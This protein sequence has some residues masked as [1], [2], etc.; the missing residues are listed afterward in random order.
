MTDRQPGTPDEPVPDAT[1]P[2]E[3]VPDATEPD[4][5]DAVVDEEVLESETEDVAAEGED[6]G[7]LADEDGGRRRGPSD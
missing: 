3:P 6:D 5:A 7:D 4:A 2:D 1:E